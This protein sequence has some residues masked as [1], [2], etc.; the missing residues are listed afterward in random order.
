[1]SN[2]THHKFA[3]Y[4]PATSLDDTA[5]VFFGLTRV[6]ISEPKL[7]KLLQALPIIS[8]SMGDAHDLALTADG[9]VFAWGSNLQGCL[10]TGN[11]IPN[12]TVPCEVLRFGTGP[13]RVFC[14]SITT[15]GWHS[16]ALAIDL[17]V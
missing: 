15:N 9:R 10:G 3:V 13:G 8:I 7:I 11:G 14:I 12:S 4:R 16:G 6:G 17:Q 1:M 5:V 2:S